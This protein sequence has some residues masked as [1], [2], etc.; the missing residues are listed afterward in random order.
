MWPNHPVLRRG[1]GRRKQD[2]QRNVKNSYL[3]NFKDFSFDTGEIFEASILCNN[4]LLNLDSS[5]V[6]DNRIDFY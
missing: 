4:I 3:I 2:G 5:K 1:K 6:G